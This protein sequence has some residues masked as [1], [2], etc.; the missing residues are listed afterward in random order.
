[1][2]QTEMDVF[3]SINAM[4]DNS[5]TKSAKTHQA[6][7][8]DLVKILGY[9]ASLSFLAIFILSLIYMVFPEASDEFKGIAVTFPH[10]DYINSIL[11]YIVNSATNLLVYVVL[12]AIGILSFVSAQYFEDL[13]NPPDGKA[14]KKN[15]TPKGIEIIAVESETKNSSKTVTKSKTQTDSKLAAELKS[16]DLSK[17]KSEAVSKKSAAEPIQTD[18]DTITPIKKTAVLSEETD[19]FKTQAQKTTKILPPTA[20]S[21]TPIDLK[22][23]LNQQVESRKNTINSTDN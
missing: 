12:T 19:N 16:S 13:L 2:I 18:N 7:Y 21:F 20:K 5:M 17:A 14:A 1:M 22:E 15:Q 6:I 8:E 4:L 23:A 11:L 9:I 3:M 10:V